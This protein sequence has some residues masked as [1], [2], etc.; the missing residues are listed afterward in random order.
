[1]G[2]ALILSGGIFHDFAA[3]SAVLAGMIR[4]H[5]LEVEVTEDLEAGF[6]AL[7]GVDLLVVNALRWRMHG[8]KYDEYRERWAYSPSRS[9]REAVRRHL[10]RGRGLLAMHTAVICFDDWPEWG[11]LLGASWTWGTSGHPPLA[12]VHVDVCTGAH[13]LVADV[14][15]FDVEDEVYGFLER[16]PGLQPLMTSA[17]GGEAH[18]LLW[19]RESLGAPVV[20]DALGHG[21]ESLAVPEHRTIVDRAIAWVLR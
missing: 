7:D 17:H 10:G 3:T 2:R 14:G 18:P 1:M 8:E 20:V 19:V 9:A 12:R 11:D 16:R 13:P 5:G 15:G 21:V 6:A 4:G